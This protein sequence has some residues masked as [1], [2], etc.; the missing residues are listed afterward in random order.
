LSGLR[1]RQPY[2]VGAKRMT[3]HSL[4]RSSR[5]NP[6]LKSDPTCTACYPLFCSRLSRLC[7]AFRLQVGP[8][9]FIR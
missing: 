2:V 3:S 1:L 7:L 5:P 6:P 9:S 8:L 4:I